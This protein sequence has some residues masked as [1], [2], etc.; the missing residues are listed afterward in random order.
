MKYKV[1]EVYSGYNEMSINNGIKIK[2]SNDIKSLIDV[3]FEELRDKICNDNGDDFW[4]EF[5]VKEICNKD[6]GCSGCDE[7]GFNL[8]IGEDNNWYNRLDNYKDWSDEEYNDWRMFCG[9]ICQLII[10]NMKYIDSS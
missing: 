9:S 8:V 6:L 10:N 4:N 3:L 7:E 1:I 2:E 5:S